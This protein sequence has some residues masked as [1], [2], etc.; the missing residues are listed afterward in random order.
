MDQE[1]R[2]NQKRG[3]KFKEPQAMYEVVYE[4]GKYNLEG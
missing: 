4:W 3:A 2:A 1:K